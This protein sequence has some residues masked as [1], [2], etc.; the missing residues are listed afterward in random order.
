MVR[1][2][3]VFKDRTKM[4]KNMTEILKM[5]IGFERFLYMLFVYLLA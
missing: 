3:K 5:G 4:A 1:M 2:L